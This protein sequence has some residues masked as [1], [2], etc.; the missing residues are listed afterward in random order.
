MAVPSPTMGPSMVEKLTFSALKMITAAGGTPSIYCDHAVIMIGSVFLSN[1][2]ESPS[3]PVTPWWN[4]STVQVHVH[5]STKCF[6][7]SV[8]QLLNQKWIKLGWPRLNWSLVCWSTKHS[9]PMCCLSLADPAYQLPITTNLRSTSPKLHI[10]LVVD[11][12]A[13]ASAGRIAVSH[14]TTVI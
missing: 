2:F 12:N 14:L 3:Q 7:R 5:L 10:Q 11:Y 13:A 4:W 6:T 8:H 1:W 9:N